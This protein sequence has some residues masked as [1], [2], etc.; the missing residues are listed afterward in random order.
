MLEKVQH[1]GVLIISRGENQTTILHEPIVPSKKRS[2]QVDTCQGG[3]GR[4]WPTIRSNP[5][6]T[7]HRDARGP[8]PRALQ[9]TMNPRGQLSTKGHEERVLPYGQ[10]RNKLTTRGENTN[11]ADKV[12]P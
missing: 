3:G 4:V 2:V 10:A 1:R 9:G 12:R 5:N 11:T 6:A 8:G 7:L